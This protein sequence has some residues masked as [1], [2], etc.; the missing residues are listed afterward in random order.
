MRT[1][2]LVLL[3]LLATS[4]LAEDKPATTSYDAALAARLGADERGMQRYMFVILTTGPKTDLAEAERNELFSGHM[5]N[6]GKL[7]NEGKLI[8][9]GPLSKNDRNY[10]GIFIFD[11][12][13]EQEARALLDTDPAVAAGLLGFEVYGWYGSAALKETFAIHKRIDKSS[14]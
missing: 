4:V 5:A 1:I 8:V 12:K 2:T 6:I 13:T 14:Q 3:L 7:A 11:V 9:A 10:R